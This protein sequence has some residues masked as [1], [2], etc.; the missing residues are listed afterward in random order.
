MIKF[1]SDF[2]KHLFP[3][4]IREGDLARL[5][6]TLLPQY[7][8]NNINRI[9]GFLTQSS[10]QSSNYIE[11][12]EKLNHNHYGLR[13]LYPKHFRDDT[14]AKIYQT[15][16]EKIANRI[17]AGKFGNGDE[18]SGDGWKFRKRGAIPLLGRDNYTEYAN[19]FDISLED[20][21]KKLE[22]LEGAIEVSCYIWKKYN[23]NQECDVENIENMTK[24][25]NPDL[26][27]VENCKIIY[28]KIKQSLISQLLTFKRLG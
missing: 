12:I 8:I 2:I 13:T 26:A 24:L 3:N 28:T 27:G 4:T 11:L 19:S 9:A 15:S 25:I 16:P 20:A 10:H 5:F 14:T 6:N 18:A 1:E 17:Y 23:V 7:E 22:T 21:I